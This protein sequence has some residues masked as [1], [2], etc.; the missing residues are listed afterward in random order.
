M[1]ERAP[2][3]GSVRELGSRYLP[4]RP[5][6]W[7]GVIAV[8]AI[9]ALVIGV[10]AIVAGLIDTRAGPRIIPG[11]PAFFTTHSASRSPRAAVTCRSRRPACR[12]RR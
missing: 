8:T 2:R 10:T 1:Q 4:T 7:I 6:H 9:V 11:W 3:R 12:T 5:L